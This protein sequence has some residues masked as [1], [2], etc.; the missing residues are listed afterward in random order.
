M[1]CD[2]GDRANSLGALLAGARPVGTTL[3]DYCPACECVDWQLSRRYWEQ[4]GPA[5]FLG[6]DV[7]Y[8]VTNDGYLAGNALSV[9]LASP[10][11]LEAM[12]DGARSVGVPDAADRVVEMVADLLDGRLVSG[13]SSS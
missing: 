6:G 9:L 5:A 3:Q 7:P 2:D 10:T 12:A 13:D 8:V 11:S 4:Q 1:K